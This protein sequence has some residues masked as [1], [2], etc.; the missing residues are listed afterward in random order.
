[1]CVCV[2]ARV[3]VCVCVCVF[4]VRLSTRYRLLPAHTHTQAITAGF[5]FHT[6]KLQRNGTYKTLKTAQSVKIHPSSSLYQSLPRWVIY[7]ELVLTSAEFMRQVVEIRP[8]WLV[9]CAP[10]FYKAADVADDAQK[11]LPKQMG[12]AYEGN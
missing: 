10:H 11:K 8:E 6:A 7:N 12:R 1:M 9:E 3:C 2:C 5:F 4:V